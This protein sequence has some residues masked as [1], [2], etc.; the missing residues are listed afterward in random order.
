MRLPKRTFLPPS[1][2]SLI[3]GHLMHARKGIKIKTLFSGLLRG[4]PPQRQVHDCCKGQQSGSML[5]TFE[6]MMPTDHI[7]NATTMPSV[8]LTT[9]SKHLWTRFTHLGPTK[10]L[11]LHRFEYPGCNS[12]KALLSVCESCRVFLLGVQL[13]TR[14]GSRGGEGGGQIGQRNTPPPTGLATL[15]GHVHMSTCAESVWSCGIGTS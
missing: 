4:K 7:L 13:G 11:S 2:H 10:S 3:C 12:I 5:L 6:F 15:L 1:C 8:I 9:L 14:R